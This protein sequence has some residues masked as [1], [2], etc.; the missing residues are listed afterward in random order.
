MDELRRLP[1]EVDIS[2]RRESEGD[3]DIGD[4]PEGRYVAISE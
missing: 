2:Q 3:E 1:I 4:G